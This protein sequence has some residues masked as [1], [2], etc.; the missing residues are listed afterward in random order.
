MLKIKCDYCGNYIDDSDEKCPYCGAANQGIRRTGN[1]VPKTIEELKQWYIDHHLPDENTTR[2]FIGKDYPGPKAFGIYKQPDGDFVVYKNKTDGTRMTRYVG[3]DETYAV[4]EIYLKLKE[5][6]QNQNSHNTNYSRSYTPPMGRSYNYI[7]RQNQPP[8]SYN[9]NLVS[10]IVIIII[11]VIICLANMDGGRRNR[12]S[13][14]YSNGSSYSSSYDRDYDSSSSWSSSSWDNDYDSSS[15]WSSSSWDDDWDSSS[16][17][18]SSWS[19]WD[20]D[21]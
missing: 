8:S 11:I 1:Q 4:Q 3:K 6:M 7:P 13:S 15:S 12:S 19:D 20:S 21:W 17:W 18:D 14:Y 10:L 2:F 5:E 9:P 16:S